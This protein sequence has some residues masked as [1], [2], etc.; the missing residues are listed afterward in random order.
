[1]SKIKIDNQEISTLPVKKTGM[2][3]KNPP[4]AHTLLIDDF[5]RYLFVLKKKL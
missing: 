3:M 1:M 4:T 5:C 2:E